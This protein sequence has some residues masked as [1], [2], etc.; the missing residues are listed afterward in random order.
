MN[1]KTARKCID[2]AK[3]AKIVINIDNVN[4]AIHID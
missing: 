1:R 2:K 3:I 4:T